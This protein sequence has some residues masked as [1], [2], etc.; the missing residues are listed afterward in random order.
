[1]LVIYM[2]RSLWLLIF[3]T[4]VL[5]AHASEKKAVLLPVSA[6]M[7]SEGQVPHPHDALALQMERGVSMVLQARGIR[8]AQDAGPAATRPDAASIRTAALRT[9]ADLVYWV[10][11]LQSEWKFPKENSAQPA[12]CGDT[13]RDE[14][15][16][17]SLL[18][19]VRVFNAQGKEIWTGDSSSEYRCNFPVTEAWD[20]AMRLLEKS[21]F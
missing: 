16:R 5:Q 21:P 7:A 9:G 4:A 3:I 6:S 20:Q 13:D 15:L 12:F 19:R 11:A 14:P 18:I 2:R 8:V 17:G 10:E 1:M